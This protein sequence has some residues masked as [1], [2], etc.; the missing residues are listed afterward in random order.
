MRHARSNLYR[1]VLVAACA[2]A[3][4]P[5]LADGMQP[6]STIVIL[7]EA[8]GETTTSVTNTDKAPALLHTVVL[9]IPED[10]DTVVIATPP[11]ARVDAGQQQL[12]RFILQGEPLKTQRLKRVTFEGI[13]QPNQEPGKATVGIGVRQNLPLLLHPKGLPRNDAPWKL[14]TWS[15]DGGT[16]TVTNDSAYV[17]RLAST[18]TLLP[19]GKTAELKRAYLLANEA[20]SLP[21]PEG[22]AADTTLR[23]SPASVYGFSVDTYDLP[24]Q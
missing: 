14:L 21:L 12:V 2:L 22:S 6:R 9:D 19:S 18:V 3:A 11:I 7:D 23:I 20:V 8:D 4:A 1:A 15:H 16:L 24:L 5:A 17:V 10:P 13:G